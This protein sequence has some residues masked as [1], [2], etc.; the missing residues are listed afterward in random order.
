MVFCELRY[1]IVRFGKYRL[2][3]LD[4]YVVKVRFALLTRLKISD[5]M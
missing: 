1:L 5:G 2:V 3:F 4:L